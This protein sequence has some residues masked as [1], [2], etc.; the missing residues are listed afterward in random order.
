MARR[1]AR[2]ARK[3]GHRRVRTFKVRKSFKIKWGKK[4]YFCR[5]KKGGLACKVVKTKGKHRRV[6]RRR[7]R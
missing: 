6:R 1:R 4:T 2:R 3:A 7:R 5:R